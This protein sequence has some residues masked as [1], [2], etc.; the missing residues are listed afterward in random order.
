[1][2]L[3]IASQFLDTLLKKSSSYDIGK[4]ENHSVCWNGDFVSIRCLLELSQPTRHAITKQNKT[5]KNV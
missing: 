3:S 2:K 5:K 4:D 1:M